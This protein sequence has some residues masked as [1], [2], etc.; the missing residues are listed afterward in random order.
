MEVFKQLMLDKDWSKLEQNSSTESAEALNQVLVGFVQQSF[1]E[2]N[3][4][5]VPSRALM[6][7]GLQKNQPDFLPGS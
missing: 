1:P 4:I 7:H 5:R 6:H 2:K 3:R